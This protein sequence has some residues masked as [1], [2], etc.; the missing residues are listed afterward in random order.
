MLDGLKTPNS[1]NKLVSNTI[2]IY[3]GN[4][5]EKVLKLWNHFF[6]W[7]INLVNESVPDYIADCSF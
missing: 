2:I 6:V 1:F 7:I 3:K 4:Y 5:P